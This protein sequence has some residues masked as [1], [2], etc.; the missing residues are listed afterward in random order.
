MEPA[1]A[2]WV[3]ARTEAADEHG[4]HRGLSLAPEPMTSCIIRCTTP[5]IRQ[6][7]TG[8]PAH[9]VVAIWDIGRRLAGRR[10]QVGGVRADPWYASATTLRAD[11]SRESE[12]GSS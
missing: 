12:A 10:E 8:E 1:A 2:A 11:T 3:G 6:T 9:M 4:G 7:A 5:R